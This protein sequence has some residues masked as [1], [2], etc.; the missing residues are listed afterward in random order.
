MGLTIY[1]VLRS[2]ATRPVW[3]AKELGLP[4][5]RVPGDPGLP[6]GAARCA[7][8]AAQH[9][10]ARL[11]HD[12]PYNVGP[13]DVPANRSPRFRA[14]EAGMLPGLRAMLHLMADCSGSGAA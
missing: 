11:S 7:G 5:E 9:R 14:D 2:R 1:G 13:R 8:R 4:F 3:L 6:T 12:Q 10:L